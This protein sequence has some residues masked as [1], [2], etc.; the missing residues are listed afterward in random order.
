MLGLLYLF[1]MKSLKIQQ[2]NYDFT[3]ELWNDSFAPNKVKRIRQNEV[4]TFKRLDCVEKPSNPTNLTNARP[5]HN[6]SMKLWDLRKMNKTMIKVDN[7]LIRKAKKLYK[8]VEGGLGRE[9]HQ[10][11]SQERLKQTKSTKA[12]TFQTTLKFV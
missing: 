8:I 5:R 6:I 3:L 1:Y 11:W 9:Q 12:L 10:S 4:S 7:R 2:S